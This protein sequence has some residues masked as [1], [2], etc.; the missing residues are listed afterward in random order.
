MS[1]KTRYIAEAV[2]GYLVKP[3]Q[4]HPLDEVLACDT[5]ECANERLRHLTGVRLFF[6]DREAFDDFRHALSLPTKRPFTKEV[7]M[8]IDLYAVAR[9]LSFDALRA[10]WASVNYELKTPVAEPD[11]EE[12]LQNLSNNLIRQSDNSSSEVLHVH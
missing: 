4:S 3:S 1:E 2:S 10:V 6:P 11:F 7:L 9:R 5:L 12:Y 8:R